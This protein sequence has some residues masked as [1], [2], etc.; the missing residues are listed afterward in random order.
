M[1]F[2]KEQWKECINRDYRNS[3]T[4]YDTPEQFQHKIES[5]GPRHIHVAEQTKALNYFHGIREVHKYKYDVR[6]SSVIGYHTTSDL[7]PM[8]TWRIDQN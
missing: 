2:Q 3:F 7:E 8:V 4:L 5:V 6:N 1:V